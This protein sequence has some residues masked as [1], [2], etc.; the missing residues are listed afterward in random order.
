MTEIARRGLMLV[1]SSPSGAGKTTLSRRLLES[2]SGLSLSV[3]MTTR[4]KR[5]GERDGV[6]Y[7]FVDGERFDT[8]V[9]NGE[10][11]E[12]AT[13]F[14]HRYGTPKAPVTEVLARGRDVLFDIDWQGTQQ[15]REK[16]RDDLVSIF[17]LPPS[18]AELERRLKARAQDSDE[19]VANR[20]AKAS[21]EISHWAEYDYVIVN[22]NLDRALANIAAI[23]EA[24]R[25]KRTRQIGLSQFVRGLQD[26]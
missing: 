4:P 12:H 9:R 11:L 20:M 26:G 21:D 25:L 2:D 14:E 17:V 15:L 16:A 5:A 10:L 1:L 24:E 6:D 7:V 23:V 8:A 3:S 13:V 18:H 19:I 22:D